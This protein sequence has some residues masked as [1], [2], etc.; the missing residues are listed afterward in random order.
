MDLDFNNPDCSYS[1][2]IPAKSNTKWIKINKVSKQ[3]PASSLFL[4][5]KVKEVFQNLST[6]LLETVTLIFKKISTWQESLKSWRTLAC[7][8]SLYNDL[9]VAEKPIEK[10]L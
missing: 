1:K 4:C 7:D 2:I 9:Y 8:K 3:I 10:S 6:S 5:T